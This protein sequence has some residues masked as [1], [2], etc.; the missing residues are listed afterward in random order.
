MTSGKPSSDVR[1]TAPSRRTGQRCG[2]AAIPFAEVCTIH[3][4]YAPATLEAADRRRAEAER[5]MT[6]LSPME[7]RENLRRWY[8]FEERLSRRKMRKAG[9]DLDEYDRE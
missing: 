7:V 8:K 5:G 6:D 3:G 4:G 9:V 2:R 1:C